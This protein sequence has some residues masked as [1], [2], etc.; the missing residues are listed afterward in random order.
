MECLPPA[1]RGA[2][3]CWARVRVGRGC[4]SYG[5]GHDLCRPQGALYLEESD[6]M[7]VRVLRAVVCPTSCAGAWSVY[8]ATAPEA[9]SRVQGAVCDAMQ[10]GCVAATPGRGSVL[11]IAMECLP[12][13]HQGA[14]RGRPPDE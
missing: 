9:H 4:S 6:Q 12:R 13:V 5:H 8:S 11:C 1:H 3:A 10:R 7:M 2:G 14:G